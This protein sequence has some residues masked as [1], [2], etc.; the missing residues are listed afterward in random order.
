MDSKKIE[1]VKDWPEIKNVK[2]IKS[3]LGAAGFY[4]KFIKGYAEIT[5]PLTKLLKG[6][7]TFI[8]GKEQEEA[9][10]KLITALTTAPILQK[11]D[12]HQPMT[13][14]TDASDRTLG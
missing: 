13:L 7:A 3:I 2:Q 1:A 5:L 8:W 14:A 10:Q 11:P 12:F 4:R 9:K 6:D